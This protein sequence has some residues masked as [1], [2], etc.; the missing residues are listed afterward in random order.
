MALSLLLLLLLH[1][2]VVFVIVVVVHHHVDVVLQ[3]LVG[4]LLLVDS[5]KHPLVQLRPRMNI[6]AHIYIYRSVDGVYGRGYIYM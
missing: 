1:L 2:Q 3:L 5:A 4:L 6:I